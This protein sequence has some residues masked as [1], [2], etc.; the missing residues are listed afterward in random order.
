MLIISLYTQLKSVGGAQNMCLSIH[1]G[2][3]QKEEIDQGFVCSFTSYQQLD[4][5]YKEKIQKKEY[6]KFNPIKLLLN[7]PDAIFISHHRKITTLLVLTAKLLFKKVKIVHVAHNEFNN[8]RFV[9]LFPKQIISVSK[10]VKENHKLYFKLKNIHVIYNG[11]VLSFNLK[12]KVFNSKKIKI[13]FP[14]RVTDVKQQ[15]KITAHLKGN[16]P[17]NVTILFAGDGPQLE[18]LKKETQE[19]PQFNVLGYV[20]NMEALY[21]EVDLVLLFSKNEGLPLSLIEAISFGVPCICNDVGGNVEVI[22][23]GKN[24]LVVSTVDALKNTLQML[25][26]MTNE[27]YAELSRNA[28]EQFNQ[29]FSYDKMIDNYYKYIVDKFKES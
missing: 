17:E 4:P 2:L 20:K 15:L 3:I 22:Q 12:D 8:L 21:N 29:K 5:T 13:L 11:I 14:G 23:N 10:R 19:D 27:T 18:M 28:V 25:P 16:L 26:A 9:S 7:H 1:T 24:G 6:L